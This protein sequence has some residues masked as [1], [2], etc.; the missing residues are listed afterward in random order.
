MSNNDLNRTVT[1]LEIAAGSVKSLCRAL[2]YLHTAF[3]DE[4]HDAAEILLLLSN[5][6][7]KTSEELA[8][9]ATDLDLAADKLTAA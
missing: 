5:S 8:A 4:G 6:A 3:K 9:L 1:N 2:S 7:F